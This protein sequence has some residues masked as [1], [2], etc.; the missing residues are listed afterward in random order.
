MSISVTS[1]FKCTVVETLGQNTPSA[2]DATRKVTHSSFNVE[3]TRNVSSV[4]AAQ[5]V[6]CFQKTLV[7]GAATIDLTSLTS[8]NGRVYDATGKRLLE[9]LITN[10][11]ATK[12]TI[13]AGA[14]NGYV[15]SN[16]PF[17]TTGIGVQGKTSGND[18]G[19]RVHCYFGSSA[20]LVS[21]S[22]KT[23][24]LAGSSTETVNITMVFGVVL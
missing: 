8:T 15:S 11:A 5:E 3:E 17:S 12:V 21:G 7:A 20:P 16:V 22:V 9:I 1:A 14:S 6:A 2:P 18:V 23:L 10:D 4:P 19:G 24:D 13:A